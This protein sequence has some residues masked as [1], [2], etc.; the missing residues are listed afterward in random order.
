MSKFG[1][2]FSLLRLLGITG[3]K[4]SFARKTGVPTTRSGL[5]RKLGNMLIRS[6]FRKK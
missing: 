1:F 4:Q 3:M 5:E 2:S 6:I